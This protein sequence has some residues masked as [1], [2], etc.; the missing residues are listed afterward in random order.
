MIDL[1]APEMQS[2]FKKLQR[3]SLITNIVMCVVT[4]ACAV[5]AIWLS[6]IT[7]RGYTDWTVILFYVL[8]AIIP[9]YLIFILV[10]E[11]KVRKGYRETMHRY[12]AEGFEGSKLLQG[13]RT[14]NL[15][16]SVAGDNLVLMR[17]E[18]GGYVQFDLAPVKSFTSVCGYIVKCIRDYV[19]DYYYLAAKRGEAD[20][21]K[22]VSNV[23]GK[24]KEYPVVVSGTPVKDRA[25]SFY[26]SSGILN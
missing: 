16:L 2:T 12:V 17:A 11:L 14:A 8:L 19:Y 20:S 18:R 4:V 9:A 13:E 22:F 21:V 7:R 3:V 25:K 5:I 1:S 24:T 15:I 26:I 10:W 6:T 23:H